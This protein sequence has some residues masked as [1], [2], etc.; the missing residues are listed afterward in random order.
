MAAPIRVRPFF[1]NCSEFSFCVGRLREPIQGIGEE[2]KGGCIA[3]DDTDHAL[4]NTEFM[5]PMRVLSR[6]RRRRGSVFIELANGANQ[7]QLAR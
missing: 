3:C 7:R 4:A 2:E 5:F 6:C 1:V